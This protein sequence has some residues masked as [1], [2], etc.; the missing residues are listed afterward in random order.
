M[1]VSPRFVSPPPYHGDRWHLL[2]GGQHSVDERHVVIVEQERTCSELK[3][4]QCE[5]LP[6]PAP[7]GFED[8]GCRIYFTEE[9]PNP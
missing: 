1:R 5:E 3:V 2:R 4:C 7:P 8:P 6:R 9:D